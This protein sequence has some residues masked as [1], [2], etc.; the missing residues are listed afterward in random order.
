[1]AGAS[2][3]IADNVYNNLD[4]TIDAQAEVM[5]LNVGSTGTTALA[6]QQTDDD[7]AKNCNITSSNSLTVTVQSSDTTVAEVSPSTLTFDNCGKK[8]SLSVRALAAGTTTIRLTNP[9]VTSPTGSFN[10]APATFTVNVSAPAPANEAPT[11]TLY[12][13][14]MGASY[15]Y[16]QDPTATCN[17]TDKEDGNRSF[18]A[19]IT[20]GTDVVEGIGTFT[21]SCSYEDKGGLTAASSVTYTVTK[22]R[23]SI[24]LTCPTEP[25]TYT[26]SA[27]TPCTAVL[28]GRDLA[29]GAVATISYSNNVNAGPA[30]AT[31]SYAGDAHHAESNASGGFTISKASP[32]VNV[33][34]PSQEAWTGSPI[35]PCSA[36]VD[37]AG[38]GASATLAYSNNTGV[39]TASVTATYAGDTNHNAASSVATFEIVKASSVVSV[40]CPASVT[41]D[42]FAQ[43]P[44]TA[45]VTGA[46]G[47]S[48]SLDV[49]YTDNTNA[50]TA[51]AS[52]NWAGDPTHDGSS[53]SKSFTINKASSSVKVTCTEGSTFT[54]KAHTPC[55][56]VAQ[57]V[58]IKDVPV[59]V[60]YENNTDAGT[61]TASAVWGGDA[62]HYGSTGT[63]TFQIA[64]AP[65][66]VE[67]SCESNL[68]YT[69]DPQVPCTAVAT[70]VGMNPVALEVSHANVTDA[71]TWM[72]LAAWKGDDNHF[73]DSA[74][75]E[76]TIAKAPSTIDITCDS[77]SVYT[78]SAIKPCS[79]TVTGV[80]GLNE[81]LEV[82][83]TD[84]VNAGT[85][86]AK[87]SWAGDNNHLEAER[88]TT[89][90]IAKAR[91]MIDIACDSGSVYTGSEIK[92]CSATVTGAG[93]LNKGLEVSYTDN[94]NAGTATATASF[95]GDNNHKAAT[96]STTFD[97]A[98]ASSTV[99]ISCPDSV[100]FTGSEITPCSATVTGAA[101]NQAV[102]V[103][104]SANKL[105]GTATAWASYDGDDN[106]TA[107]TPVS[108]TFTI[109]GFT[110][111]GFYKPV[112]MGML[113]T[114]K[115]GSTVPLKFEVFLNGVERTDTTAVKGFSAKSISCTTAAVLSEAPIE[116]TSTG[117]TSLRYDTTGGQFIQ[118]WQTPRS[119]GSCYRVTMTTIDG[120]DISADFKLK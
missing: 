86:T 80:G 10:L 119:A 101:L 64:K 104:Y 43:T 98:K 42:G 69:G 63:S 65:S 26:G 33:T 27:W 105:A 14:E 60:T 93:D 118:N 4:T 110:L 36:T 99:A 30:T 54:G 11:V 84:N 115:A 107:A 40:S 13:P 96:K 68:I 81:G 21:A 102:P 1:M 97:I 95:A 116:V 92:P 8:L 34:C 29:T 83:Y 18:P 58:G 78:G 61:A 9:V 100:W 90:E 87:A 55:S 52:T 35:E 32:T 56:A 111:N 77:G 71:G 28:S 91:S 88:S 75:V 51:T 44:C 50:G 3:A 47:L 22:I 108:K 20:A 109:K 66:K 17:V 48:Q 2:G 67:I 23:T 74:E 117:G 15:E 79:A 112:D 12:G 41:Y 37:G 103:S 120:T 38:A 5:A 73:G 113:N 24:A 89:F 94:V 31:A 57:G 62:N 59:T 6:I 16:N 76:Y 85:A 106:H 114:V 19:T 25:V 49:T 82:S 46:G 70:G 72:A 39:G 45:Q 53:D 7:G